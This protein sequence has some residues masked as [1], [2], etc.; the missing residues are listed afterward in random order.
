M[1]KGT[2]MVA[3]YSEYNSKP[4][5]FCPKRALKKRKRINP[6]SKFRQELEK[7]RKEERERKARLDENF[8]LAEFRKQ[9]KQESENISY[10]YKELLKQA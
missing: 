8:K 1:S 4:T 10:S 9:V 3:M 5:E 7:W 6:V 2:K